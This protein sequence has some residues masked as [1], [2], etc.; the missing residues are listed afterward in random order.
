[1]LSPKEGNVQGCRNPEQTAD[2]VEEVRKGF[3]KE[4]TSK[5]PLKR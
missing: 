5:L 3:Q 2:S 4:G 1:M